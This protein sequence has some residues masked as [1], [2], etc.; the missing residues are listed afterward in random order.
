MFGLFKI[1]HLNCSLKILRAAFKFGRRVQYTLRRK[2]LK[3]PIPRLPA[4]LIVLWKT[5]SINTMYGVPPWRHFQGRTR[6]NSNTRF[7]TLKGITYAWFFIY[8]LSYVY[9]VSYLAWCDWLC[10]IIFHTH[11]ECICRWKFIKNKTIRKMKQAYNKGK[12]RS[13]ILKR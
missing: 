3:P 11:M 6:G 2:M 4:I 7:F 8:Y 5:G 10:F 13:I 1:Q 9:V 12:T